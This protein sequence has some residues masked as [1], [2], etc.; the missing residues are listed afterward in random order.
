MSLESEHVVGPA[1]GRPPAQAPQFN[2]G[3][4]GRTHG[5]CEVTL[6][7]FARE[8]HLTPTLTTRFLEV[9]TGMTNHEFASQACVSANTVKAELQE[10]YQLLGVHSRAEIRSA[11]RAAALRSWN[12]HS[13]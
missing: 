3:L 8:H 5:R 10:L 6:R 11:L 12:G 2:L 9:G 13:G 7:Q 4:A 1:A